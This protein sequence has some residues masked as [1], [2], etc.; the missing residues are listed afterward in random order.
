M[1][2]PSRRESALEALDFLLSQY[3]ETGDPSLRH[4]AGMLRGQFV[5]FHKICQAGERRGV[6]RIEGFFRSEESPFE[7]GGADVYGGGKDRWYFYYWAALY[8]EKFVWN[9]K[10]RVGDPGFVLKDGEEVG[11]REKTIILSLFMTPAG[12]RLLLEKVVESIRSR[13]GRRPPW[14]EEVARNMDILIGSVTV[15]PICGSLFVGER[16]GQRFCRE[17]CRKAA[18]AVP[19]SERK[20]QTSKVFFYRQLRKGLS[21]EDAWKAT[22]ARHGKTLAEIG[23]DSPKPPVS[24]AKKRGE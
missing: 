21:R 4:F 11:E 12:R 5:L 17:T 9:Q 24:W 19:S 1:K 8:P 2:K 14:P 22:L 16:K 6:L 7:V 23:L 15:C 20:D 3:E 13:F 18:H 10:G